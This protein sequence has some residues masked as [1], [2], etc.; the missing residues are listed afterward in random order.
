MSDSAASASSSQVQPIMEALSLQDDTIL[1]AADLAS[2]D[3]QAQEYDGNLPDFSDSEEATPPAA[4]PTTPAVTARPPAT[5]PKGPPGRKKAPSAGSSLKK[6]LTSAIP[7]KDKKK[8]TTK[9]NGQV[10]PT[11]PGGVKLT[12]EQLD[13][14]M[15]QLVSQQPELE[16]K[17]TRQDVQEFIHTTGINKKVLQGKQGLMGKNEKDMA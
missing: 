15:A 11:A 6:K 4:T 8:A 5:K 12:N 3:E 14:V 13:A 7:G 10:V 2:D 16:G 17:L 1:T 9:E